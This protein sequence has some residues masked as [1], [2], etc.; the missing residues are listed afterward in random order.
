MIRTVTPDQIK[1]WDLNGQTLRVCVN[2]QGNIPEP[3][4]VVVSDQF[5]A[6]GLEYDDARLLG[7]WLIKYA[8]K[9]EPKGAL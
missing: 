7:E 1:V 8:D 4:Y 5:V 9:N 3:F 6:C 2:R